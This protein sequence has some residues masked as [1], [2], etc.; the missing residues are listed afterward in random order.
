MLSHAA[1]PSRP[2]ALIIDNDPDTRE[3]YGLILEENG[4]GVIEGDATTAVAMAQAFLPD[5]ITT[6]LGSHDLRGTDLCLRLKALGDTR[7]IPVIVVTARAMPDQV[8]AALSGGCCSV[9]LKP[10]LPSRLLS[11]IRR[12]LRDRSV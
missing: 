12:V 4:M 11:E 2:L 10:C 7:H 8:S 1:S 3:M 6:D 5:V 9:L